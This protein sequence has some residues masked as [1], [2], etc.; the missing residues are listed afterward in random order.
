[1]LVRGNGD[2]PTGRN[3]ADQSCGTEFPPQPD[4]THLLCAVPYPL[5][6][7]C[8]DHYHYRVLRSA[9]SRAIVHIRPR[10]EPAWE[11]TGD[12]ARCAKNSPGETIVCG[13]CP[14]DET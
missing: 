5:K 6:H 12:S 1:M 3:E 4:T 13:S 11:H 14:C 8:T 2:L 9:A 10:E 7:D